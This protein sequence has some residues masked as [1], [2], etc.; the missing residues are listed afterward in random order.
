MDK[1]TQV[2]TGLVN[3]TDEGKLTW[4]P[5]W[6]SNS[7]IASVDLIGVVIKPSGGSSRS[8]QRGYAL[9]IL[10][11]DGLIAEVLETDEDYASKVGARSVTDEQRELII[12]LFRLAR[13]S[14]LDAEATLSELASRLDAIA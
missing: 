5:T 9:E 6:D 7:F 11:N 10:N 3:R 1:M 4:R 13:G 14:A 12:R 8:G 2:L